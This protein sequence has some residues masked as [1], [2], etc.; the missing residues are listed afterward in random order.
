MLTM[1]GLS[2]ASYPGVISARSLCAFLAFIDFTLERKE[3]SLHA[4]GASDSTS[5]F[6]FPVPSLIP[7]TM[8]ILKTLIPLTQ[9]GGLLTV[10]T[11][12]WNA[13]DEFLAQQHGGHIHV[14]ETRE[15]GFTLVGPHGKRGL[16]CYELALEV[17]DDVDVDTVTNGEFDAKLME[18]LQRNVRAV[19]VPEAA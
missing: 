17:P 7:T 2:R 8:Q 13:L 9:P 11:D 1:R 14:R 15:R 10:S 5:G 12:D 6:S 16:H 3:G 4:T 19:R 18:T